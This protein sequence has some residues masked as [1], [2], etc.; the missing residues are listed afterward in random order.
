M[1]TLQTAALSL[2]VLGAASLLSPA[3]FAV[4]T[5]I[6]KDAPDLTS[7]RAKIKAKE[8]GPRR[9]LPLVTTDQPPW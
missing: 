2:F 3:A 1:R 8:Q 9:F 5:I 6:S 7:A 4:D